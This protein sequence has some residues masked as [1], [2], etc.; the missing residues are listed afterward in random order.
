M[1]PLYIKYIL[2]FIGLNIVLI[3]CKKSLSKVKADT[4]SIVLPIDSSETQQEISLLF[5]G[6]I[7]QHG[8]QIRAAYVDSLNKYDYYSC[9][10]PIE[11]IAKNTDVT[12]AN[13]EL[14]LA[15]PPY[16]GY[17]Q[18]SAPDN[19]AKTLKKIGIHYLVTANNHSCDRR[20]HG[21][22]RT[23][24][25]LDTLGIVHTGTFLDSNDRAKNNPMW[26]EKNGIKIAVLNYTYGTNGLSV[27][28]PLLVNYIDST[29]ILN[30]LEACKA[31]KPDKIIV[32]M[33]WGTEYKSLPNDYQ[34]QY[35]QLCL[36]NGADYV[37]GS[38]PH[39]LQPMVRSY[40]ST[41]HKEQ[42]VVY[43]LGNFVSNQRDRYKDGGTMFRLVLKKDSLTTTIKEAGYILTWVDKV[44]NN[45]KNAYTIYPVERF[46]GDTINL[47]K[48]SLEK[49]ELFKS[50]SEQLFEKHNKNIGKYTFS[51][52]S[53]SW[54]YTPHK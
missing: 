38:H 10:A 9:F 30:D 26:I 15:G 36:K 3:S 11:S 47:S 1:K 12:I 39:V 4:H 25:V 37:I 21:V 44:K 49:M 42:L 51:D 19:L 22:K 40:D 6:D 46:V 54:E 5:I 17:P 50:D 27:P 31:S 41:L 48:A 29:V 7:M 52:S 24:K 20:S 18:F 8:P 45:G 35:E 28:Q 43:S 13:L 2:I 23:I 34:K 16:K 14:T 53:K 32:F 33:H